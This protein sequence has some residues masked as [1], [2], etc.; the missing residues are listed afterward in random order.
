MKLMLSLGRWK[1][2]AWRVWGQFGLQREFLA[3]Q[4]CT[5]PPVWKNKINKGRQDDSA[6]G[7]LAQKPD[8]GLNLIPT[9]QVVMEWKEGSTRWPLTFTCQPWWCGQPTHIWHIHTHVHI[10][11]H[12]Y[13]HTY[14]HVHRHTQTQTYT[15]TH[16][17]THMHKC[18]HRHMHVHARA[19][20]HIHRYTYIY[21]HT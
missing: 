5:A 11:A 10:H 13:T 4:S 1:Q 3:R 18:T 21:T 14:T 16:I 7:L 17:H 8:N 20:T 6:G 12:T 2:T 19:H 15:H 9:T